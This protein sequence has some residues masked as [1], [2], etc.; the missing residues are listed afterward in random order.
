VNTLNE[1]QVPSQDVVG[2][3]SIS[4]ALTTLW[5]FFNFHVY[6]ILSSDKY[7]GHTI[8]NLFQCT[9]MFYSVYAS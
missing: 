8:T 7:F 9:S 4:I 5:L 6:E 2:M 3:C 1:A